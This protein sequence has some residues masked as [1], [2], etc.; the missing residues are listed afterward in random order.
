MCLHPS[1]RLL[2][3]PSL[4]VQRGVPTLAPWC[5]EHDTLRLA[6]SV[7]PVDDALTAIA[8]WTGLRVCCILC[9]SATLRGALP[10][11]LRGNPLPVYRLNEGSHDEPSTRRWSRREASTAVTQMVAYVERMFIRRR[12]PRGRDGGHERHV[13]LLALQT[14]ISPAVAAGRLALATPTHRLSR[15]PRPSPQALTSIPQ[16]LALSLDML[17]IRRGRHFLEI[18]VAVDRADRD[19]L[20]EAVALITGVT[21]P[22]RTVTPTALRAAQARAYRVPPTVLGMEIDVETRHGHL[23]HDLTTLDRHH[24]LPSIRLEHYE[25]RP[26]VVASLPLERLHDLRAVPFYREGQVLWVA[27]AT[28]DEA[29]LRDLADLTD[30]TVRPVLTSSAAIAAC[31]A[32]LEAIAHPESLLPRYDHPVITHLKTRRLVTQT[33]LVRIL[34][35]PERPLDRALNEVGVLS[36]ERFADVV[37]NLS[38]WPLQNLGLRRRQEEIVD[39][40][41][42]PAIRPVWDDPVDPEVAAMLPVSMVEDLGLLALRRVGATDWVDEGEKDGT[43]LFAVCDPFDQNIARV[44]DLFSD[45][46]V[47]LIVA[48]RPVILTA[49]AR[50]RGPVRLGERLQDAGI[51]TADELARALG[52]QKTA[53][54]RLG[55]ALL[56]LNVVSQTQLAQF[57][58]DQ[59]GLAFVGLHGMNP[60]VDLAR[61]LPEEVERRLGAM[62]LYDTGDALVVATP[63]PLNQAMVD[64]VTARTR[65]APTFVVCTEA[66]LETMLESLYRTDYLQR[67][68]SEL[69]M[70][71]PEESA[72]RVL[73]RG[74]GRVLILAGLAALTLLWRA[75][76]ALGISVTAACTAFYITFSLYRCYLIYRALSHDHEVIISDEE[77]ASVNEATLPIY[78]ILVPLYREAAVLPILLRGLARLDYPAG[79]LDVKLL[80]E[81]DDM[82]T[83]DAIAAVALPS[84]V[85]PVVVPAAPPR[86]KPKACNYGLIHARGEYVVIYDAEDVPDPD[87][88]KKVVLAFRKGSSEVACLQAK[89][90]YYNANQNLLTSWFS[91]EYAMWFDL[92]LP[93]LN[94]GGVPIPLGG[95]SNHFP[96]ARLRE[97]GAWDPYNVTEDADLGVRLF[98]R[99][100]KTAVIDSTT[101][102]EANS[103]I[104]N[105]IRQRS[106]WV[107]GYIQTFLVHMRHPVQ[108]WRALGS[109]AFFSFLMVVGGTFVSFLLNPIFW[110]LTTL[111]YLSHAGFVR[112]IYPGP[113]FYLG[114]IS[115]FF[116]NFT[117][118]YLTIAGCLRREQYDKV[119]YA[120]ISPLYWALISVAA[121]KGF[122]QL[123]TNPFY[124]EKTVH[125]LYKNAVP[126][127]EPWSARTSDDKLDHQGVA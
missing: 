111:W 88:L 18:A 33:Q 89:L 101:Y 94:A 44:L 38:G 24:D 102:E 29:T 42:Q 50:A 36:Y 85:Q 68:T 37:S 83:L 48:P 3:P 104:Y 54:V 47:Q 58:A 108:L 91:T 65:R 97:V 105:W 27:L 17:P 56:S 103:E 80:L 84:Y 82:E 34:T 4:R 92:F 46:R 109:K 98:R 112:A 9:E 126:P 14:G 13:T 86:G 7:V 61:L 1:L 59:Q 110:C 19:E 20:A 120:L 75:P 79:K 8:D 71:T 21:V 32:A 31:L 55:Q 95:T 114:S 43:L 10:A 78:T 125:G 119:K 124:W 100:W 25:V 66:D 72:S 64:E 35:D 90:N 15:L 2:L 93:G 87:Q 22:I 28:P 99:G 67:S 69:V 116:G 40:F 26:E 81:E 51:I 123:W 77:L 74:Q 96:T 113:V 45:E 118:I 53:G 12:T 49:L 63:D 23:P 41:G 106:R 11:S 70:R 121:W 5:I 60:D 57:L 62:P 30:L 115:L 117:F 107:K 73:T 127:A 52:L 76:A 122:L 39:A 6:C 16:Q